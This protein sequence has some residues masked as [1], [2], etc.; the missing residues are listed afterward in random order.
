MTKN[1]GVVG[2]GRGRQ[3]PY[4]TLS[5]KYKT[6]DPKCPIWRNLWVEIEILSTNISSVKNL[7]LFVGKLQVPAST[8]SNPQQ[9]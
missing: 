6:W 2:K 7:G 5:D 1:N 8:F 3:P 4:T 9:R